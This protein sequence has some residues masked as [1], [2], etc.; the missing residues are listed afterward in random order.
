MSHDQL[1]A[2]WRADYVS[3]VIEDGQPDEGC[4]LCALAADHETVE[5][6]H[7]RE[8]VVAVLNRYPYVNGH[9]MVMPVRHVAT[10]DELDDDESAE[11]WAE[12]EQAVEA[13]TTAYEPG[14]VNVG[15][16][17][18]PAAGAGIPGH[19]HVHALPRWRGDTNFMTTVG[20][21]RVIPEGPEATS[22]RVR[23]AWPTGVR[24][25]GSGAPR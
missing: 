17:M 15:I 13:I 20:G 21:V 6:V 23:D 12:V 8:R 3:T 1:W 7:R 16:N 18:G 9:L 22:A 14:G 11:L 19:L 24:S 4:V 10:L 2:A 25:W 5:V